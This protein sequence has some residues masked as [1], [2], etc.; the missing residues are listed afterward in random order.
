M[1]ERTTR[2]GA[3][4]RRHVPH[5]ARADRQRRDDPADRPLPRS[6][7]RSS[8]NPRDGFDEPDRPYRFD[9]PLLRPPGPAPRTRRARRPA[10]APADRAG[11][12]ARPPADGRGAVRRAAGARPHRV[13]GRAA[14]HAHPRRCS[15]PRCIHV[16]STARPDGT[17][18]LAGL[19]FSEPDWWEKSGIFAGLNTNKKSVTLDLDRRTGS[20]AAPPA[21]RD[22]RRDRR[23][24]HA[25][26]A[27]AARARR[28]RRPG[29]PARHR[30]W[31]A[32]RA[33]DSTARG[34]T[35]P[36]SRS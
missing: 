35:T 33:S 10:S 24:L 12:D 5:P 26:R 28:R 1:A 15:A 13:L 30:R 34:A 29:D 17:R 9:P 3:R 31:C 16:E 7:G 6:A 25:P 36:P 4:A 18:L 2:R 21:D 20:R 22:L 19:R 8:P 11:A 14:L 23:E 32:C 27:G